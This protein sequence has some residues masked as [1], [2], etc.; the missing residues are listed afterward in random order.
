MATLRRRQSFSSSPNWIR[1]R[2]QVNQPVYLPSRWGK[3][4][5][6][7]SS[8]LCC[9]PDKR[10]DDQALV[11]ALV[12]VHRVDLHPGEG[13]RLEQTRD[14]L[15]LLPVRGD[16]AYVT[17]LTPCLEM[18]AN[19]G[20]RA[21]NQQTHQKCTMNI[22]LDAFNSKE[23]LWAA[24]AVSEWALPQCG[25]WFLPAQQS[26][27]LEPENNSFFFSAHSNLNGIEVKNLCSVH[28]TNH[29]AIEEANGVARQHCGLYPSQVLLGLRCRVRTEFRQDRGQEGQVYQWCGR[30]LWSAL[31]PALV[32]QRV[33]ERHYLPKKYRANIN[34]GG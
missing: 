3:R 6:T 2:H 26:P 32:H 18:K 1:Q 14:G 5:N 29:W 31:Q 7:Y 4:G 21:S 10:Q 34:Y 16:D 23:P 33:T 17:A 19:R 27:A 20:W 30:P 11:P 13:R 22:T 25:C 12:S 28:Y 15:Y 8:L 24:K 9:A